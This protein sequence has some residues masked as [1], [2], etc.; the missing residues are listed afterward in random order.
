[1][2]G[3]PCARRWAGPPMAIRRGRRSVDP[4][5]IGILSILGLFALILIGFHVGV[6]LMVSS[7]VGVWAI[8]GRPAVAASL[9]KTTAFSAVA[10]YVFA[11]IPL[12]VLMGLLA[13]SAGATRDLFSAAAALL[14]R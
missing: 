4:L 5:T 13:T 10:D 2:R 7:Y 6:A 1:M 8:V 9:L 14:H 3:R 12:F 11:V